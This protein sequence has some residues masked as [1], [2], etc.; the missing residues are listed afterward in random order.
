MRN[1]GRLVTVGIDGFGERVNDPARRGHGLGRDRFCCYDRFS[2]FRLRRRSRR[3]VALTQNLRT[4]S[5]LGRLAENFVHRIGLDQRIFDHWF[6]WLGWFF[7][8]PSHC[9]QAA[10]ESDCACDH[11]LLHCSV[12]TLF[13]SEAAQMGGFLPVSGSRQINVGLGSGVKEL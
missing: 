1:F 3:R 12:S 4:V 2:P 7:L 10:G 9:R 11:D 5:V 6:G 8:R 13:S